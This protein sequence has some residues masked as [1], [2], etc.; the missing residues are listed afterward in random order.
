M[1]SQ[2][3]IYSNNSLL[4]QIRIFTKQ[5]NIFFKDKEFK[6]TALTNSRTINIKK[7]LLK[8]P[9][10]HEQGK[11]IFIKKKYKTTFIINSTNKNIKLLLKLLV[12]IK[13]YLCSEHKTNI[14]LYV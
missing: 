14:K 8:S 7:A 9:H 11:E 10:V 4:E 6:I 1:K 3:S 5:F 12:F 2:I 13:I